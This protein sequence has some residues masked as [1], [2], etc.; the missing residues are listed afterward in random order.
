MPAYA[1]EH[2]VV[3]GAIGIYHCVAR[4]VRHAHLFGKDPRG[5]P[6]YGHRREWVQNRLQEL[7]GIYAIDICSFAVM[8]NHIHVMARTRPDVVKTWPDDELAQRCWQLL[9][10]RR[11]EDGRPA[12]PEEYELAKILAGK[13]KLVEW[14]ERFSSLSWLMRSLSEPLARRA[15]REDECTGR[16]WEGRFKSQTLLDEPAALA[17]CLNL[18]L[19]PII[20]GEAKTPETA[21]YT[22][23]YERLRARRLG[24]KKPPGRRPKADV[25]VQD[26]L[27]PIGPASAQ[28]DAPASKA[29]STAA[30]RGFLSIALD[31]YLSLL[32]WAAR[33]IRAKKR[34]AMPRQL[35]D[36]LQ[37]MNVQTE[38]WL[39][40]VENFEQWFFHAVGTPEALA[41]LAEATDRRWMHGIRHCRTSF[42]K[43]EE[44]S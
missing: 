32:K 29:A 35:K 13:K 37:R 7:A 6:D 17:C 11:K 23:A 33:Q 20:A 44:E 5:G 2:I 28:K 26:W 9:P 3:S 41:S 39:E 18:D 1:R 38:G 31:E 43:E 12:E 22:G 42:H 10:K 27:C 40:C 15:N 24:S 30:G 8:S 25:A 16:F 4:C 19:N 14:R 36:I 21:K 34:A